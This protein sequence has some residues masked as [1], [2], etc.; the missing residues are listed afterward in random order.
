MSF[1]RVNVSLTD[2]QMRLLMLESAATGLRVGTIIRMLLHEDIATGR[3]IKHH[4]RRQLE[5]L[6]EFRIHG[7]PGPKDEP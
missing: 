1:H 7:V 2:R 3:A 6:S 5:Q 4:R